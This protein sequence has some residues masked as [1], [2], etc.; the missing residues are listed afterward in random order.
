MVVEGK[1]ASDGI[2]IGEE[3]EER[4]PTERGDARGDK[5]LTRMMGD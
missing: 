5:H 2:D 4:G 3:E 1:N